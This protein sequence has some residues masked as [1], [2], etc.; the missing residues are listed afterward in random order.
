MPRKHKIL[1]IEDDVHIRAL[2]TSVVVDEG[3]DITAVETAAEGIA[4]TQKNLPDL[5]LLDLN[6][7][8]GNGLEIITPIRTYTDAPIIV[9]SGAAS[10]PNKVH[11]LDMG[12]DDFVATPI[13]MKELV[14]RIH[15]HRP[16]T[17]TG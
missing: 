15:A 14:A 1:L 4:E 7:P 8:D 3:Y 2:L 11:G 13:D 9:V 6:L 16:F 10:P 12:A 5:I 17:G